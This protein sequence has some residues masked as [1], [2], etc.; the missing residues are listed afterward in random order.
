MVQLALAGKVAAVTL[1]VLP[2]AAAVV[3]TPVQVPPTVRGVA[4]TRFAT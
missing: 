1:K 4:F 2:P 3:V